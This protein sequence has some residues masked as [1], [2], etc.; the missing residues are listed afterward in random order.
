MFKIVSI[1]ILGFLEQLLFT[2]YLLSVD[3][4]QKFMSSFLMFVYFLIY[5]I[6]IDWAIKDANT[7]LLLIVYAFSAA[8]GN[9]V[10]MC[11]EKS[12]PELH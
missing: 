12:R 8:V 11:Y 5:L 4:R 3:K 1:F 7:L 2:S 9:Y 6:I 10:R